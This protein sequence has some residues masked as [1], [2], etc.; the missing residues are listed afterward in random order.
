MASTTNVDI[1]AEYFGAFLG[2]DETFQ[3]FTDLLS[4]PL[5]ELDQSE[6]VVA[7]ISDPS[8]EGQSVTAEIRPSENQLPHTEQTE[9][10]S[11]EGID[12]ADEV[13][14][15]ASHI[16]PRPI[17]SNQKWRKE[18]ELLIFGDNIDTPRSS[19]VHSEDVIDGPLSV[20]RSRITEILPDDGSEILVQI[21]E[22][23]LFLTEIGP[24]SERGR[25]LERKSK[26]IVQATV[27]FPD[28]A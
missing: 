14:S 12:D 5:S 24:E 25:K 7:D 21:R 18:A 27:P 15:S 9:L 26:G 20:A 16:L 28:R 17:T 10:V 1:D 22:H 13:I 8:S 3:F 4:A 11:I 2:D 23:C 6:L 19:A